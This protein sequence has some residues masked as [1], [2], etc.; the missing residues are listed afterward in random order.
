MRSP[1]KFHL[2][3]SHIVTARTQI[4]YTLLTPGLNFGPNDFFLRAF[5]LLRELPK[6][7]L[8]LRD[9]MR[10]FDFCQSTNFKKAIDLYTMPEDFFSGNPDLD[11]PN[12][13]AYSKHFNID[14]VKVFIIDPQ[15][16]KHSGI[17]AFL[18]RIPFSYYVIIGE[19]EESVWENYDPTKAF[20]SVKGL[21]ELVNRDLHEIDKLILENNGFELQEIK[22]DQGLDKNNRNPYYQTHLANTNYFTLN[23]F[24]G[25]YWKNRPE[26]RELTKDNLLTDQRV[27][28]QLSQIEVIDTLHKLNWQGPPV[29]GIEPINPSM[30]IIAPYHF[31]RYNKILKKK[32]NMKKERGFF[33]ISQ[34]EQEL[35]YIYL[36]DDEVVNALGRREVMEVLGMLTKRFLM[37]DN[38]AYLHAQFSYSPVFRL[39][40]IG[41]SLNMDLS[42]LQGDFSVKKEA[43]RKM[44]SVGRKMAEKLIDERLKRRLIDRNGQLVFIS[45]LPMEWLWL[46]QYPLCMTHDIC[47]IPEFNF[48]SLVNNFVHNQRLNYIIPTDIAKKTLVIHCA[49]EN[50]QNMLRIFKII[51]AFKER[52]GFQ[53]AT[54]TT[55]AEIKKAIDTYEPDLLIFDCHG[56]FDEK[57][58]SSFLIIDEKNKIYL[59]GEDIIK[60]QIVAPLV[61]I[62][63]CSTMPSYGYVKFLSDAFFQ[64]GAFVVT[65]TFLPI[66]MNDTAT[67]IVRLISNL[68][69]HEQQV[70]HSNWLSFISHTLRGALVY[71]TIRKEQARHYLPAVIDEQ[72]IAEILSK[73]MF[74]KLRTKAYDE[75]KAYLTS[76]NAKIKFDFE[77]L[78]NEWLSYTTMG[79]ADLIY[80]EN[81]VKKHQ[82]EHFGEAA[83]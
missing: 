55:V 4:Q 5:S 65:A 67:L 21:I 64:A 42:H 57:T 27:E 28:I 71:E 23:Q 82:E 3:A 47:R 69:S 59:T 73:I 63:A 26:E 6:D 10:Y 22:A 38:V 66:L 68:K 20:G 62:S 18:K 24:I 25:N 70:V 48:S 9:T 80:F 40:V 81:W 17:A 34:T 76:I 54:C 29:T 52:L 31:P 39:P 7:L 41:K 11:V 61:F 83:I 56:G 13:N 77:G 36:L 75:L 2:P 79:R 8:Q 33:K 51:D 1:D 32:L 58:L 45:D 43:I 49:S 46:D 78:N 14:I 16:K 50:D 12:F 37:L 19:Q 15:I 72:K 30:I 35:N 74:F 60:N 53:S 44:E